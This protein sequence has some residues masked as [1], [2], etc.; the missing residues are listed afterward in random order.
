M[1]KTVFLHVKGDDYSALNFE[2]NFNEDEVYKQMLEEGVTSK[3]LESDEYYIDVDIIE[4]GEVDP[5]FI[6]FILGELM[7]YDFLKSEN[8]YQVV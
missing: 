2:E 6:S 4:F 5:S 7:D 3:T 8:I 1:K